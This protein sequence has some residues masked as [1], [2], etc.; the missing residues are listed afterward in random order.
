MPGTVIL[1]ASHVH[2]TLACMDEPQG[3]YRG[4]VIAIMG[5]L[6]DINAHTLRILEV[7]GDEDDEEPEEADP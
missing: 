1:R 4:E 6:A 2:G 5:A 3:I 7:L